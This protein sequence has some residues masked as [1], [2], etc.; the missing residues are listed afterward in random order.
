SRPMRPALECLEDRIA[1]VVNAAASYPLTIPPGLGYDDVVRVFAPGGAGTGTLLASD[2]DILTAAHIV[3]SNNDGF[4]DVGNYTIQFDM[5]GKTV[6]LNLT[7]AN[8]FIA[9]GWNG[10]YNQGGD[11]AIIRL[12]EI[13]PYIGSHRDI[14][15]QTNE[16]GNNF[17]FLGYGAT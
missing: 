6:Q 2:T 16:V 1:P 11:I 3:D 17:Y 9:P 13:S 14:Y 8:V 7:Q 12:N 15:R 10:N 5:A 4:A